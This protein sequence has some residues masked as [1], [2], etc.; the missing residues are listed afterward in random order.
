ML[1]IKKELLINICLLLAIIFLFFLFFEIILR[2]IE[3][4]PKY[5]RESEFTFYEFDEYLGWKNRPYAE[6]DFYMP[7]SKSYVKINS[8][9]LRDVEHNYEKEKNITRI[10]FYGDSFTWGYGVNEEERYTSIFRNRLNKSFPNKYEVMNFGVAGYGTDQEYLLFKK[11]GLKYYPNIVIFAYVNDAFDVSLN[12]TTTGKHPRPFF[13]V[14]N[15]SLKLTNIPLQKTNVNWS[16]KYTSIEKKGIRKIDMKL[17]S[18]RTY[19]FIR[20]KI[21]NL[22]PIEELREYFSGMDLNTTLNVIDNLLLESN[23]ICKKNN[24]NFI[25][26]LIPQKEQVYG[27]G[28]T[29]EIDHLI[30]FG[31]QNNITIINLLPSLKKISDSEKNIYF[32]IDSH[33]SKEGNE[34][35]G[36]LLFEK[37]LEKNILNIDKT[38]KVIYLN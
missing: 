38:K 15:N 11:E 20:K 4:K 31:K 24:I 21:Y 30:R 26:V 2:I 10:Q 12:S 37:F 22:K 34:I 13:I 18:L 35:M 5:Q 16:E 17:Q 1:K 36:N 27:T 28:N 7:N 8:R 9:G 6:G 19:S 14:E 23:K 29:K 3:P 25:V 33:F 32:D